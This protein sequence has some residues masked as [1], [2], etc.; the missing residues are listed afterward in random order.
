MNAQR[1]E[2]LTRGQ[3]LQWRDGWNLGDRRRVAAALDAFADV[4][5]KIYTPAS[6]SYIAVEVW[7][8]LDFRGDG[9]A[10]FT[11]DGVTRGLVITPGRLE[12]P[13]GWWNTTLDRELFPAFYDGEYDNYGSSK[14][15][16]WFPLSTWR[17]RDPSRGAVSP[18]RGRVCPGCNIV[19][20]P[21]GVCDTCD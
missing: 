16:E 11:R 18:D 4:D 14:W 20:P 5:A 13:G 6:Q 1:R 9:F 10:D 21:T 8:P 2:P 7:G 19:R 15:F 12:W 3:V 17:G